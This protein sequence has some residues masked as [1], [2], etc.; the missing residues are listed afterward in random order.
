MLDKTTPTG[1]RLKGLLPLCLILKGSEALTYWSIMDTT[2]T[3]SPPEAVR[4]AEIIER[5][6]DDRFKMASRSLEIAHTQHLDG[7]RELAIGNVRHAKRLLKMLSK[8]LEVLIARE[9]DHGR[10]S[11]IRQQG[12][13][14]AYLCPLCGALEKE[15]PTA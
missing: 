10:P 12:K 4:Q 2:T 1:V 14:V 15:G 11:P 9:C 6:N 3:P 7:N 8:S 13:F 5:I